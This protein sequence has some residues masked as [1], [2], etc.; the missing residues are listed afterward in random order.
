[1]K[2]KTK[3]ASRVDVREENCGIAN[4][5]N[6]KSELLLLIRVKGTALGIMCK[7]KETKK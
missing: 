6:K 1:M 4:I 2:C 7:E 3:F 5:T